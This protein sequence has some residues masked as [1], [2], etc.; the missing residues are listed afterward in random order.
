MNKLY[1]Y[2][3]GFWIGGAV[4]SFINLIMNYRH[5]PQGDILL[6]NYEIIGVAVIGLLLNIIL[7]KNRKYDE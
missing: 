5:A 3:I 4:Y 1:K 2:G 7:L 6:Y